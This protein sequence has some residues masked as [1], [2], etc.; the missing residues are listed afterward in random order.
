M[1][2]ENKQTFQEA[3]FQTIDITDMD[4]SSVKADS[5]KFISDNEFKSEPKVPVFFP[6]V[7]KYLVRVYP[8]K[9]KNGKLRYFKRAFIQKLT[10]IDENNKE[11]TFRCYAN[12]QIEDK[13]A[14]AEK[15][16]FKD[17]W[18][19]K[20]KEYIYVLV[21]LIECPVSEYTSPGREY[22]LVLN[23]SQGMKFIEFFGSLS[24]EQT[25]GTLNIKNPYFPISISL[26]EGK[27][28]PDI[29]EIKFSGEK[30]AITNMVLPTGCEWKGLDEV[31]IN[32]NS[33]PNKDQMAAFNKWIANKVYMNSG[34]VDPIADVKSWSSNSNS[35]TFGT[36]NV[37][38]IGGSSAP[39]NN[40]AGNLCE[41]VNN[42]Q[43]IGELSNTKFGNPPQNHPSCILCMN[44]VDCSSARKF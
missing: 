20:A 18:K 27:Y 10:G 25:I 15:N 33:N 24:N 14:D 3:A 7:G 13:L 28:L 40:D 9:D 2:K 21:R 11:I 43:N 42:K 29:K 26:E 38:F 19:Y 23:K 8:D 5:T 37:G 30:M 4:L 36:N 31:Y 6:T 41:I 17:A 22:I 34:L 35:Q 1:T 39:H 44:Q 12:K 16:G 32:E